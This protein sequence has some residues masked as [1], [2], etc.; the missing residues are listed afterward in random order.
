MFAN[1]INILT[2]KKTKGQLSPFINHIILIL[3]YLKSLGIR[4]LPIV[5]RGAEVKKDAT[6]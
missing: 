1:H 4:V 3:I 2:H 5:V 6:L